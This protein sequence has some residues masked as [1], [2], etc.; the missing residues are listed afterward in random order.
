VSICRVWGT[1]FGRSN[2]AGRVVDYLTFY[3]SAT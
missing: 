1:R 3:L 2:L